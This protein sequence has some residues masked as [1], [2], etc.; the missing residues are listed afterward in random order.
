MRSPERSL[1]VGLF[2]SALA[3]L[4]INAR[5]ESVP[6]T[7]ATMESRPQTCEGCHALAGQDHIVLQDGKTLSVY[8]DPSALAGSVHAKD[9]GC[10]D[11][12]REIGSYPHTRATYDDHRAF[13]LE[14]SKTCN[15]CHYEDFEEVMDSIHFA[16][17]KA[18]DT[19]APTCVDCHGG[20][21]IQPASKPRAAVSQRCG[22]CHEEIQKTY[23]ASVHG[24]A[25]DEGN[26]DVPVCTDCH[27]THAIRDPKTA[28]F[29]TGE[30]EICAKCHA[31]GARMAKYDLSADVLGTYLDDFH[32]TSNRLYERV[33]TLGGRPVATC[34]DCHGVHDIRALEKDAPE[35]ALASTEQ[36]CRRCHD[37]ANAAFAAAWMSHQKVSLETAPVVLG[38]TWIY[39]IMIPVIL[40]G[41][42]LHIALDLLQ[43]RRKR[44]AS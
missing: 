26:E 29:H 42:L 5:A 1:R 6:V 15:R 14:M 37:E 19:S 43:V 27:G 12:H 13:Q 31:D 36:M 10:A 34:S 8:V 33:G 39:R 18:G 3:A 4:P 41:L 24:A 11:C 2:V 21:A 22:Q 35:K 23:R 25:L 44:S 28:D 30:H 20:H 7:P 32:G 9:V 38:I 17:L 16:Q 40:V